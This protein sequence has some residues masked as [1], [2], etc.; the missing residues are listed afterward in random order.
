M[1]TQKAISSV[2]KIL[3]QTPHIVKFATNIDSVTET[4]YVGNITLPCLRSL[5][6]RETI[7]HN[8]PDCPGL[9][10][11]ID[12]PLLEVLNLGGNFS[13]TSLSA[14]FQRSPILQ[15][16]ILE[17]EELGV[18]GLMESLYSC[19]SLLSLDISLS[20]TTEMLVNHFGQNTLSDAFFKAFVSNGEQGY[21]CPRLRT[22][23]FRGEAYVS[24]MT[25]RQF[26]IGRRKGHGI[27]GLNDWKKVVLHVAEKN[28]EEN[29][30][31]QMQVLVSEQRAAGL[32]VDM[33]LSRWASS[34][35]WSEWIRSL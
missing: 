33:C 35:C 14:L 4:G 25:I 30:M 32:D 23:V 28:W 19:P 7:P 11:F 12:A 13:T 6:I 15:S 5:S 21:L 10:N 22:F 18:V 8:N 1:G 24:V 9:L 17:Y 20:T 2:A 34:I 27:V 16:L 29:V 31:L 3:Q 26:L